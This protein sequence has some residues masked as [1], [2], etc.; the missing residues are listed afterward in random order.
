MVNPEDDEDLALTLNSRKNKIKHS[1]FVTAFNTIGLDTKQQESIFKKMEKA[2]PKW[3]LMIDI[4]F[5]NQE[6]KAK[7]KELIKERFARLLE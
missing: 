2:H 1:D 3:E 5:L 7:Y 6:W 4:S